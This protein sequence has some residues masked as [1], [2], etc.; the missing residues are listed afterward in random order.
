[1]VVVVWWHLLDVMHRSYALMSSFQLC[2][3]IGTPRS[4]CVDLLWCH[5]T[6]FTICC[7]FWEVFGFVG[8]FV[9]VFNIQHW[10]WCYVCFIILP[11]KMDFVYFK[12]LFRFPS[13]SNPGIWRV[14]VNCKYHSI[15]LSISIGLLHTVLS[16]LFS[17]SFLP[18]HFVNMFMAYLTIVGIR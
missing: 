10:C 8:F 18:R 16:S 4:A 7:V 6:H 13:V 5:F 1:M 3:V 11:N 2:M 17:S 15:L 14:L 9:L 12:L